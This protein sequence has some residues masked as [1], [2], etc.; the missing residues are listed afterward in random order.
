MVLAAGNAEGIAAENGECSNGDPDIATDR[1]D[2]TNSS[3]VVPRDSVQVENGINW[4]SQ[5]SATVVDGPNSRVRLGIAQCTEV[6]FDLPSYSLPLR[7]TASS[8]FSDFSPAIKRQ[9]AGL[10]DDIQLSATVGL[11]L[12]T[13]ATRIAGSG[14]GAYV[15]LPWSK[16]IG[17]G[18]GL[19]GMFTAFLI[20]GEPANNPTF[21]PTFAVERR[22]GSRADAFLEYVADHPRRGVP[23]Q[24]VD[25]GGAYRVTSTQQIDIRAGLGLNRAAP[26]YLFGIGY[27]FRFDRVF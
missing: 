26:N 2:V 3:V 11:E 14:Y 22:A 13:G 5:R 19:S 18:W 12:P 24:I 10:P 20:P 15:Q 8:G 27:S 25:A 7:G 17:E 6:L 16:E 1:P 23:S 4:T 9:L 21:E